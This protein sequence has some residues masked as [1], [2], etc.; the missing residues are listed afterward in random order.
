MSRKTR[1]LRQKVR[2][3]ERQA[4]DRANSAAHLHEQIEMLTRQKDHLKTELLR[5]KPRATLER[6]LGEDF[7]TA[8]FLIP[9]EALAFARDQR[10]VIEMA[11]EDFKRSLLDDFFQ[12]RG[13]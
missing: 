8:R 7:I 2:R 11:C 1:R 9:R 13:L 3:L 12:M 6:A 10:M 4:F 5:W